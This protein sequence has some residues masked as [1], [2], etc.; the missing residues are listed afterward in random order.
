MDFRKPL[1]IRLELC[2][3]NHTNSII[4]VYLGA[5]LSYFPL[6]CTEYRFIMKE[7]AEMNH[8]ELA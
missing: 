2:K 6:I 5:V 3:G 1:G 4:N 8:Y 7:K